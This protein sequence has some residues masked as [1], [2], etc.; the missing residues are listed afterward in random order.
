MKPYYVDKMT[1]K[2]KIYYSIRHSEDSQIV[3]PP[4]KY[5]NHKMRARRSPYTRRRMAFSLSYY[6]NFCDEQE[7]GTE[8]VL[9]LKYDKQ[10]EH[11]TDFLQWIKAGKHL[12]K[13]LQKVPSNNTCNTYLKDVFGYYQFLEMYGEQFTELKIFKEKQISYVNKA[14]VRRTE[15][16]KVFDGFLK[17][18]RHYGKS[19]EQDQLLILLRECAN[20]RDLVLLLLL[21]ETGFRIGELLG[22][23]YTK[24]IDYEKRLI[25]V[26][27]RGDNENGARAKNAEYR[28]ALV[29][30][31]TFEILLYYL[32][33]YRELM[34]DTDYLFVN[35]SGDLAGRPLNVNAVYAM[36]SRLEK[37]TGV[38]ATPHM[39]RHYFANQRR[40]SG[41]DVPLISKALGHRNL[42]TTINYLN[43]ETS[44]LVEA[45]EEY[46]NKNRHLYMVDELL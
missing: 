39:L 42:E 8:A 18:E 21:A 38:K 6:L 22:V 11:F 27:F 16:R 44:E 28:S 1:E 10:Y 23:N 41:W 7:V 3:I 2:G 14:G 12:S 34:K 5:L 29:S 46:Y 35:I 30:T 9:A 4:T 13:E 31:D 25:K 17:G 20:Y 36:L 19:I 45:S 40:K 33:E 43:I 37:K 24:D 15:K 32:S 26:Y